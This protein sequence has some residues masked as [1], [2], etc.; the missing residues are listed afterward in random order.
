MYFATTNRVV[1]QFKMEKKRLSVHSCSTDHGAAY[2]AQISHIH[3]ELNIHSI[4]GGPRS[5]SDSRANAASQYQGN[6]V[7]LRVTAVACVTVEHAC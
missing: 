7:P 4:L 3:Y 5:L 6:C 1:E 2:V